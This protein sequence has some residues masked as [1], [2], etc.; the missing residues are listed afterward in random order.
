MYIFLF[1][2]DR[3][4]HF[5]RCTD[6]IVVNYPLEKPEMSILLFLIWSSLFCATASRKVYFLS[7]P[8]SQLPPPSQI[9]L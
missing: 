8:S 3:D 9:M 6:S 7:L 2:E 4:I 5:Y 1:T